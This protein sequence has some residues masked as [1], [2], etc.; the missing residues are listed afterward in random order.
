MSHQFR[1]HVFVCTNERSADSPRGCCSSKNSLEL[2]TSLKRAARA[3]GLN[4]VRVNKAGCLDNCE[5]GPSCVIYPEATWYTLPD[6]EEG[7]GRII[8]HLRGGAVAEEFV[9]GD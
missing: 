9:M 2:L 6:E 1:K 4:D 5:N 7:L 3:A 8:E